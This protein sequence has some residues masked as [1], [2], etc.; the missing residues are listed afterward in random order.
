MTKTGIEYRGRWRRRRE[1]EVGVT[2]KT[3]N[4][5]VQV[6]TQKTRTTK[7]NEGVKFLVNPDSNSHRRSHSRSDSY[8]RFHHNKK[9]RG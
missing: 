6:R 2:R 7:Q 8:K 9:S 5:Y 4:S 3:Q 1:L